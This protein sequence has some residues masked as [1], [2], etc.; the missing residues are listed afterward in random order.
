VAR[1]D[2]SLA[3]ATSPLWLPRLTMLEKKLATSANWSLEKQI[4][5]RKPILGTTSSNLNTKPL[6]TIFTC[7]RRNARR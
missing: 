3:P 7:S 1:P 6:T 2:A 4:T 5:Y